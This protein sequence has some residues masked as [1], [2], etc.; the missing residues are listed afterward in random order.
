MTD[1]EVNEQ[2]EGAIEVKGD[3]KDAKDG[4]SKKNKSE[5]A[6]EPK[7]RATELHRL[8]AT[9]LDDSILA[10]EEL[11]QVLYGHD[12][13]PLPKFLEYGFKM[14][15]DVV[16]KPTMTDEVVTAVRLAL[17]YEYPI[18]PRGSSTWALG[19][20]VP[21]R[22][23]I[24]IDM[25]HF[26]GIYL[27][28]DNFSVTVGAGE[29]WK[30]VYDYCLRRG[31]LIG[32]YPSS[33]MGS[34]VGGWINTGGIGIG[35]YKYGGAFDQVRGL[36]VVLPNAKIMVTGANSTI[37]N[38]SGY[39]FNGLYVGSE[40]TLGVVTHVTLKLH[41]APE[42]FRPL[43]Y[44]LESMQELAKA[45][46]H[47]TRENVTPLH[48]SFLDR[49]HL[50]AV[51]ALGKSVPDV[52]VLFNICLE[53]DKVKNDKDEEV[54][55]GAISKYTGKQLPANTAEHEWEERFYEFRTK[56]LGPS[57]IACSIF[58]PVPRFSEVVE[59][60]EIL[61]RNMKVNLAITGVVPDRSTVDYVPYFLT[62]E[63]KLTFILTTA[64][65][66]KVADIAFN[67]DGYSAGLGLWMASNLPRIAEHTAKTMYDVKSAIDPHDIMNPGKLVEIGTRFGFPVP[68][69]AM[70]LGMDIFA[71][72][73]RFMPRDQLPEIMQKGETK[74]S[75]FSRKQK[76]K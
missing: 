24:L 72:L 18:I 23:G 49:R 1:N 28:E 37:S 63:R 41:P 69:N 42:E 32:A 30:N 60:V 16:V 44:S 11:E 25:S 8:L 39:N 65:T 27:D 50:N 53:G 2:K 35:S 6:A 20:S 64:F 66:K 40:G 36:E 70:N 29:T 9:E 12:T 26:K 34:T 31:F 47:V 61:G 56:R 57:F 54:L 46:F 48:I 10:S 38:Q 15:P 71:F 43:S 19:G 17:K 3:S 52:D 45:I 13:A 59:E 74:K 14:K 4:E 51:K 22:G 76:K 75:M 21:I 33:A 58:V 5:T 55:T 62:D 68:A 67:H 73:K 7:E